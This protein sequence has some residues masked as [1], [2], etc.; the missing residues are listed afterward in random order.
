MI[1][2]LRDSI[3]VR[4]TAFH[5]EDLGSI[6]VDGALATVHV[7]YIRYYGFDSR[8]RSLSERNRQPTAS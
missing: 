4:I 2:C 8:L 1:N 6:P 7:C 5:A 3:V